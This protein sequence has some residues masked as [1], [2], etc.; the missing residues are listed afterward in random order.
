MLPLTFNAAI[1]YEIAAIAFL[2]SYVVIFFD[3]AG[4]TTQHLV[5]FFTTHRV[6][7]I[8]DDSTTWF[9]VPRCTKPILGT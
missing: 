4:S 3:A 6:V 5:G 7:S 2:Q 9:L 8:T 1:F